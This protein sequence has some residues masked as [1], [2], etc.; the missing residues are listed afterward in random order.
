M[1]KLRQLKA[2]DSIGG[3]LAYLII[4]VGYRS[5]TGPQPSGR[6]TLIPRN[7]DLHQVEICQFLSSIIK[8]EEAGTQNENPNSGKLTL[9]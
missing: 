7:D 4:S 9:L 3:Y 1:V 8:Y 2:T 5:P 6:A